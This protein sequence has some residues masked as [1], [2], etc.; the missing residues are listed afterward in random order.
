[1]FRLVLVTDRVPCEDSHTPSY[2]VIS[3]PPV[4]T[5]LTNTTAASSS[6]S[7]LIAGFPGVPPTVAERRFDAPDTEL[8]YAVLV[9]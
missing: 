5:D 9:A 1:M 6:G 8:S 4:A 7:T 2:C 3:S